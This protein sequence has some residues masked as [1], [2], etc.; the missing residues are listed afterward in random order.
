MSAPRMVF[1]GL[2]SLTLFSHAGQLGRR[3][4]ANFNTLVNRALSVVDELISINPT[5]ASNYL[6]KANLLTNINKKKSCIEQAIHTSPYSIDGHIELGRLYLSIA[7]RNYA[8][9]KNNYILLARDCFDKALLLDPSSRNAG[10]S[11]KIDLIQ[12][13]E[14]DKHKKEFDCQEIVN[15]L[16]NQNQYS[17]KA[18]SL[19]EKLIEENGDN[20]GS[21]DALLN[22]ISKAKQYVSI[23]TAK[24]F[25]IIKIRA[26]TKLEKTDKLEAEIPIATANL[27]E[28]QDSELALTIANALRTKL[29]KDNDA[30]S[31]LENSIN[32]HFENGLFNDLLDAYLDLKLVTEADNLLRRWKYQLT[33]SSAKQAFLRILESQQHYP[34]LLNEMQKYELETE[35]TMDKHRIYILLKSGAY[36]D[37]EKLARSILD[38]IHFTPEA[39]AEIVNFEYAR[40]KLGKKPDQNRLEAAIKYDNSYETEAAAYAV[41]GKKNE[42]LDRIKKA[43]SKNK[44][45]IYSVREWPVFDDYRNDE[46]F[47]K[48]VN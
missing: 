18:L 3:G 41:L 31:I 4:G 25:D 36:Q 19:R 46:L 22:D 16:N 12:K 14:T 1:A 10:W 8:S 30:I 2:G 43:I 42:M 13:Y 20:G 33:P 9:S 29:G 34:S 47:N 48:I 45:Y 40:K 6:L 21:I 35:E 32:G 28:Y 15:N 27:Y 38:K 44:T 17:Y 11:E 37:A 24:I 26:L 39:V 23:E 5:K 7:R